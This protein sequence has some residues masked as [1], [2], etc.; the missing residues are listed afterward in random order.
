MSAPRDLLAAVEGAALPQGGHLVAVRGLLAEATGLALPV[1]GVAAIETPEGDVA[2]EVVGFRDGRTLVMPL[3]DLR[4]VQAG[5]SVSSR[6]ALFAV[7]VGT[8]LLGRVVDGLDALDTGGN[9]VGIGLL[10]RLV[11]GVVHHHPFATEGVVGCQFR[12]QFGIAY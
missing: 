6:G 5:A 9:Q 4:G 1:G 12:P 2:A 10:Y 11:K 8:P 3:G 7:P